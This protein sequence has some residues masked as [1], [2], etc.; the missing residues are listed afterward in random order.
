MSV[1]P[2]FKPQPIPGDGIHFAYR[3]SVGFGFHTL[4]DHSGIE[5]R[6][7][8][9]YPPLL[10]TL[11]VTFDFRLV[12][13]ERCMASLTWKRERARNAA[14]RRV[15]NRLY[16]YAQRYAWR[17]LRHPVGYVCRN[18]LALLGIGVGSI[19]AGA[20]VLALLRTS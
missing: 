10:A 20:S 13:C 9:Y 17:Y 6:E 7:G 19:A 14:W 5:G 8:L 1:E 4:I 11:Q 18:H 12:T 16:R 2:F 15:R 3:H